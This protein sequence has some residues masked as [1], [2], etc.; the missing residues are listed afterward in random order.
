MIL[1]C[2]G[3]LGRLV[4]NPPFHRTV[5][6]V[7]IKISR[8]KPSRLAGD[9]CMGHKVF[10]HRSRN[11]QSRL[12]ASPNVMPNIVTRIDQQCV[13]EKLR[14]SQ[15]TMG[16]P[17]HNA[18]KPKRL[19]IGRNHQ[20]SHSKS[21]QTSQNRDQDWSKSRLGSSWTAPGHLG[22]T[23]VQSLFS[24]WS[25]FGAKKASGTKPSGPPFLQRIV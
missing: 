24:S 11:E 20:K 23:G 5:C 9:P 14:T 19:T 22:T 1:Q 8:M 16:R 13:F 15:H 6:L 7:P 17:G 3:T 18:W 21:L 25:F 4:Y 10:I 12:G 2:W